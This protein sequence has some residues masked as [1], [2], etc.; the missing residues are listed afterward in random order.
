[1][2][3]LETLS[4]RPTAAIIQIAAKPF[5]LDGTEVKNEDGSQLYHSYLKED[6]DAASCAMYGLDFDM[7]TVEWWMKNTTAN[8][9]F[10]E[11]HRS[12]VISDALW[13][14]A[15]YIKDWLDYTG[16]EE[17]IVWSQGTDFDIAILSN[18]YRV[19]LGDDRIPWKYYNVRDARTY[20]LEA[21]RIFEPNCENPNKLIE[22]KDMKHDALADCEWSIKAVQRA[23]KAFSSELASSSKS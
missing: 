9:H 3:D 23:F 11:P 22:T 1:M 2:V 6:V 18:A 12:C 20:F 13:N 15:D 19:V 8:N 17:V 16:S 21:A 10:K 5:N 7:K 14:L 4:L